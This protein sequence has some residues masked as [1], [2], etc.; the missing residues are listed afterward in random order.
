MKNFVFE[1]LVVLM[2]IK[3]ESHHRVVSAYDYFSYKQK[4]KLK[5]E[6]LVGFDDPNPH[7]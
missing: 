5:Y 7:V 3:A 1:I 2:N 4:E 6:Y